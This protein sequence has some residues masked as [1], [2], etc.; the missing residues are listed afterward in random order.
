MSVLKLPNGSFDP[1]A[2][3]AYTVKKQIRYGFT[4]TNT[5][6]E[7]IHNAR[8][9]TFS[10]LPQTANQKLLSLTADYPFDTVDDALGNRKLSFQLPVL[11]PYATKTLVVTA[12]LALA[13]EPNKQRI[14]PSAVARYTAPEKY[15]ELD[16]PIVAR[17]AERFD[18]T[19]D[20]PRTIYDWLVQNVEDI[21]YIA[22]DRG[23]AYALE[24]RKGDCTEYMYGF[25]ALTRAHEIP[26]RSLAGFWLEQKTNLLKAGNY[27]NWAEFHDGQRWVL[28][29]PQ[30]RHFDE[31]YANY[32]AF[33]QIGE[34]EDDPMGNAERFLAHDPRLRIAMN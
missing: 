22:R 21:G 18:D 31:H 12:E 25:V 23:A 5:T 13:K 29:D 3:Q 14:T 32:I 17:V 24:H 30:R 15:V 19:S 10:P 26:S 8:F 33:R 11:P 2:E 34:L 28:A 1:E 16:S 4:I 27:H 9:V 7:T 6:A 20:K